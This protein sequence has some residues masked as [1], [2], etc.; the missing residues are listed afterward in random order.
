MAEQHTHITKIL[1]DP[2]SLGRSDIIAGTITVDGGAV[3]PT[4]T[5]DT[6]AGTVEWSG[7]PGAIGPYTFTFQWER[8][9]AFQKAAARVLVKQKAEAKLDELDDTFV[10]GS[11]VQ[12]FM[13]QE[14]IVYDRIEGRP[15]SPSA[16]IYSTAAVLQTVRGDATLRDTLEWMRTGYIALKTA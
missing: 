16:A 10:G 4:M 3:P 5:I 2:M 6:A 7:E 13:T 14:V 11:L 12:D 8:P 9:L 1:D 15:A